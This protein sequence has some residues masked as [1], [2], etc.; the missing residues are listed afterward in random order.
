MSIKPFRL[1]VSACPNHRCAC[2]SL[3]QQAEVVPKARSRNKL[4]RAVV[5]VGSQC[6]SHDNSKEDGLNSS[7]TRAA[8]ANSAR[9][10]YLVNTRINISQKEGSEQPAMYAIFMASYLAKIASSMPS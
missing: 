8:L 1:L 4:D 9:L 3:F 6:I 7:G 2:A 10:V 5:C